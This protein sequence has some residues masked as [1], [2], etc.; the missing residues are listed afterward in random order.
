[1]RGPS[2]GV[3]HSNGLRER[4]DRGQYEMRDAKGRTIIRRVATRSDRDRLLKMID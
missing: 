3:V 1:V 2:V 4:I